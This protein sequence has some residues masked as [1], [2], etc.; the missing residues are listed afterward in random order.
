MQHMYWANPKGGGGGVTVTRL[1]TQKQDRTGRGRE[2]TEGS[3]VT[4]EAAEQYADPE[5]VLALSSGRSSAG[6]QD[7]RP[8]VG[9]SSLWRCHIAPAK[10]NG[11]IPFD[12]NDKL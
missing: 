1:V 3:P 5:T 6:S 9:G 4:L 11:P 2:G 7:T 10:P 8:E 12:L